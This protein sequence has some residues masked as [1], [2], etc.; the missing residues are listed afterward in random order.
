MSDRDQLPPGNR[1][2][3]I[4]GAFRQTACEGLGYCCPYAFLRV[5]KRTGAIA[6][7]LGVTERTVRLWKAKFKAKEIRCEE[8]QKCLLPHIRSLGK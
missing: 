1:D 8:Q 2:Q 7:R 6:T 5:N 3:P 4:R